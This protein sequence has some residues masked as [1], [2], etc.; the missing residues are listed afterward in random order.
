MNRIVQTTQLIRFAIVAF[1]LLIIAVGGSYAFR[2]ENSIIAIK[3]QY[4]SEAQH[5]LEF[6]AREFRN[7]RTQLYSLTRM[8]ASDY[9]VGELIESPTAENKKQLEESWFGILENQHWFT[10]LRLIDELGQE[11]VVAT[12]DTRTD[13]ISF[14][15]Q[16]MLEDFSENKVF[17]GFENSLS[18]TI[19]SWGVI[20]KN[21][22]TNVENAR[23]LVSYPIAF[24]GER[25]G[26]VVVT[27]NVW[28]LVNA[29]NYSPLKHIKAEIV[30]QNGY[31]F[32]SSD[33][34]KL[35]GHMIP[36]RAHL[37]LAKEYPYSW[38]AIVN[39]DN[40]GVL[41]EDDGII[42]YKKVPLT[43]QDVPSYAIV[44][45]TDQTIEGQLANNKD[46]LLSQSVTIILAGALLLIPAL[47]WFGRYQQRVLD[48]TLAKAALEGMSAVIIADDNG[49]IIKV[50]KEFENMTGF[51]ASRVIGRRYV[52]MVL[53]SSSEAVQKQRKTALDN[54]QVW[55]GE[56][57]SLRADGSLIHVQLREQRGVEERDFNFTI[58][59]IIDISSQKELE[60]KLLYLSEHDSLSSIWNRR[61][62]DSE[63][64]KYASLKARYPDKEPS[65]L[66]IIDIDYFKMV[67]DSF[68]HDVGDKVIQG[69]AKFLTENLRITDFV[70]R[71]G[72]EEF[73]VIMPH[74]EKET[75]YQVLDRLRENLQ[76]ED[77]LPTIS[78]SIGVAAMDDNADASYKRADTALY[79]AKRDGRNCVAMG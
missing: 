31:Y 4:V 25:E 66:A 57:Q 65:A 22:A 26:Y 75:A 10:E 27:F 70:A 12:V 6:T 43:E 79:N 18:N 39:G 56:V 14:E 1:L 46:V 74:T 23:M 51:R 9:R 11:L 72:G 60:E 52:D 20:F 45:I 7:T 24:Q 64:G 41:V 59:S 3:Q 42:V 5:Q 30:D 47:Y 29:L 15:S 73:A 37:S 19:S 61:K 36:N 2:V 78:V 50:N 76:L 68:G 35:F 48:S 55:Q 32:A 77:G 38:R 28:E 69:V 53:S 54:D 8:V 34:D 13:T 49:R 63:L 16:D 17:K 44:R 40:S 67:N 58:I 71:V 33:T 62:F 21:N